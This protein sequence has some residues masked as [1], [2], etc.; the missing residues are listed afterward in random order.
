MARG[1]RCRGESRLQIRAAATA[2][3]WRPSDPITSPIMARA[4]GPRKQDRAA[5]DAAERPHAREAVETP[6]RKDDFATGSPTWLALLTPSPGPAVAG[7]AKSG[8]RPTDRSVVDWPSAT[9]RN[10]PQ[11]SPAPAGRIGASS[12]RTV[13]LGARPEQRRCWCRTSAGET[14]SAASCAVAAWVTST[15]SAGVPRRS[16]PGRSSCSLRVDFS[17]LANRSRLISRAW[18]EARRMGRQGFSGM[19]KLTSSLHPCPPTDARSAGWIRAAAA[20]RRRLEG[21]G[22][23]VVRRRIERMW[24]W[25]ARYAAGVLG[26]TLLALFRRSRA[27]DSRSRGRGGTGSVSPSAREPTRGPAGS[28]PSSRPVVRARRPASA[29]ACTPARL[30]ACSACSL[31]AR[32]RSRRTRR[33]PMPPGHRGRRSPRPGHRRRARDRFPSLP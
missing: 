20:S 26:A 25:P 2:H 31:P 14:W 11:N 8:P 27:D 21:R 30:P 4:G 16:G 29:T 5:T 7:T 13:R 28:G 15:R 33:R 6:F 22:D 12:G 23:S 19:A 3:V 9:M 18:D 24:N 1:N 10:G 17:R 32:T